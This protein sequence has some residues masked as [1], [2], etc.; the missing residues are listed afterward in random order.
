MNLEQ[1]LGERGEAW[2]ALDARLGGEPRRRLVRRGRRVD[3]EAVL[4]L[5]REY[6]AVAADLAFARRRFPEEDIVGRLERLTLAGRQAVYGTRRTRLSPIRFLLRD[7]PRLITSR[8]GLLASAVLA[9]F[10]PALLAALWALHDPGAALGLVPQEFKRAA[11]P[12]VY[13]LPYGATTQAALA[14]S[15]FTNNIEVTFLA[16]AGGLLLGAGALAVLAY[17]GLILGAI[18]GITIGS[19]NFSVLVRYIAPHGMLELSCIAVAGA[20]GMRLGWA[21]V[22][23]GPL[24]RGESLRRQARPAV[25][26]ILGTAPFLVLAGCTEGFVTPHGLPVAAA[27]AVGLTEFTVYW[28]LVW[29]GSRPARKQR[30]VAV[31][32]R[33]RRLART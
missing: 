7:Y 6:R 31:H 12:H 5:G 18:A 10:L 3:P 19:G 25:G 21:L 30:R 8:P 11:H 24:P 16:F 26:M 17:N 27:L 20:A 28:S 2:D 23:A 22:D 4:S 1:F 14:S 13:R 32:S 29:F 15:I 33:A 9:T